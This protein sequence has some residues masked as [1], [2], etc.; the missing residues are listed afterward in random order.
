MPGGGTDG[1]VT[2]IHFTQGGVEGGFGKGGNDPAAIIEALCPLGRVGVA[3]GLPSSVTEV[4][5]TSSIR[6]ADPALRIAGPLPPSFAACFPAVHQLEWSY[7][8]LNGSLPGWVV[9]MA[10]LSYFKVRAN[11]FTGK[12]KRR[13]GGERRGR[14]KSPSA[15][16]PH[17]PNGT[18]RYILLTR[19]FSSLSKAPS[20]RPTAACP[21]SS[22]WTWARTG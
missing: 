9:G 20:P 4:D 21:S 18:E 19:H 1:R 13:A 8:A 3:E 15:S 5:I 2:N 6:N 7:N 14:S 12:E 16:A 11:E 17:P 22:A 10:N